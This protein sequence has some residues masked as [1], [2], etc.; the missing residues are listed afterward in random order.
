MHAC[1][2]VLYP[3]TLTYLVQA[4]ENGIHAQVACDLLER[5]GVEHGARS[6]CR[7]D[8]AHDAYRR[9]CRMQ[10]GQSDLRDLVSRLRS[11]E[12]LRG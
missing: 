8:L 9:L 2:P 11:R 6:E 3:H 4:T 12:G 5:V 1:M 10:L 7:L